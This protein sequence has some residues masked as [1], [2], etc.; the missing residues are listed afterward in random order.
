ML[1]LGEGGEGR[2][3]VRAE[4]EKTE[5]STRTPHFVLKREKAEVRDIGPFTLCFRERKQR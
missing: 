5:V 2:A 1:C 4:T 3:E